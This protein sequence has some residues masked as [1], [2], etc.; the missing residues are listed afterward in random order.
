MLGLQY[1]ETEDPLHGF[2]IT[3]PQFVKDGLNIWMDYITTPVQFMKA[4]DGEK[5]DP[6][7]TLLLIIG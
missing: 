2:N 5:A 7:V 6:A 4:D 1:A 3:I